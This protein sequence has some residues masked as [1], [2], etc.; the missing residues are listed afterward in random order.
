MSSVQTTY[1]LPATLQEDLDRLRDETERFMSGACSAAEYRAFRVPQGVYEQR[2][3]GSF[4]LRVRLPAGSM[5]PHQMRTLAAIARRHGSGRLHVTTRQDIQIHDV[6]LAGI[7]PALAELYSQAGLSSKGGGGNTVR[8]ITACPDAGVC[9]REV[10]DVAPYAVAVTE[11]ML[12]D[13]VSFQLPRKYKLAFSGCGD[14][15]VAATVNDLGFIARQGPDDPGFAVYVGGG[16][17]ASSRVGQLLEAFVPAGEVQLVAE[18]VKRVFDQHGNRKNKHRA[19]LRYLV[20]EQG[21]AA[22]KQLYAGELARLRAARPPALRVRSSPGS[23]GPDA[24]GPVEPAAGFD[25]W[26]ARNV[27]AQKQAGYYLVHV[28]L[29]LGDVSAD[30]LEKLAEVAENHGE[31]LVRTT[32]SQNLVMRWASEADLPALHRELS[33]LNLGA[34]LVP[35][36][37]EAIACTGAATCKLGICLSQGLA[38]AIRDEL[39]R[40]DLDLADATTLRLHVNG[41]P[42]SCGRHPIGSLA[43]VGAARRVDSRLVPHYVV[44]LGGRVGEGQTR[45]A[46][47]EDS[48]PAR[49]VP[50]FVVEV[51]RAF[52]ESAHYPDFEAFLEAGG[53]EAAGSIAARH[54]E[55][56]PFTED[57]NYYY[58]WGAEEPFSLAGRSPG[59]CSAGVFDLIRVDLTSSREAHADGKL[60]SATALAAR[61]M[62]ITR[63]EEAHD[64]ADAL[65]L[66]EQHFLDED[67]VDD[68]FRELIASAQQA[69]AAAEA[70]AVFEADPLRVSSFIAAVESLYENMDQ[71]LRFHAPTAGKAEAK[72][73]PQEDLEIDR[74][75]DFHG[76]TCPLNYVKTK[77]LLGQMST[78]QVLAVLL[79]EAG[80]RSVPRS[81]EK[82]GHE[83]LS[84]HQ[85]GDRW[86]VIIRKGA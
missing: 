76:V 27:T 40:T 74:E 48:L 86:R 82:D 64:A 65:R 78:G 15:C 43:L 19:R 45:L 50:A 32:L 38:R 84:E 75:A 70:E 77:L 68:S 14:D 52:R 39:D 17:G 7:H 37:R 42:N 35:V 60:L 53:R 69:I 26:R 30:T 13:P 44:Q 34:A 56:P 80:G 71:S 31:G 59:E 47:G 28:P 58:D 85:Q 83:V 1:E 33:A 5:L 25:T 57:R 46:E 18:A 49:R 10:F 21:L 61:A 72:A 54:K 41:C 3:D 29:F 36:L 8:N 6:P 12:S 63:G 62:L 9:A 4:M 11:F 23:P 2:Q 22:F 55:V 67:L 79:D 66:F 16:M 24:A 51:L 81:A 20:E 73:E